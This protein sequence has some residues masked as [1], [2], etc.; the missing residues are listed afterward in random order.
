M[1]FPIVFKGVMHGKTITLD[2]ES[3]LPE[4]YRVTMHLIV[5]PEEAMRLAFGGWKD[6]TPEEVAD[7]ERT[8]SEAEGRPFKMPEPDRS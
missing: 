7:F 4:G 3:F 6:M 1:D 5:E 2:E 8:V